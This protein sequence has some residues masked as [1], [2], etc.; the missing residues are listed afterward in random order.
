MSRESWCETSLVMLR[1]RGEIED[2]I[3]HFFDDKTVMVALFLTV[4]R[5]RL[6]LKFRWQ[7][8]QSEDN[9]LCLANIDESDIDALN[10]SDQ[11]GLIG[12]DVLLDAIDQ[13][14]RA[15]PSADTSLLA[16]LL[17]RKTAFTSPRSTWES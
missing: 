2:F 13:V 16:C 4:D 10:P 7:P 8:F 1:S 5:E 12:Q 11:I 3:P 6:Q 17:L 15:T 14:D 9:R